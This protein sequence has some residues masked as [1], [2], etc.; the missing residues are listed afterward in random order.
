MQ[1]PSRNVLANLCTV[2]PYVTAQDADAG[3]DSPNNYPATSAVALPC[4][5]QCETEERIDEMGRVTLVNAWTV[6]FATADVTGL[7]MKVNDRIDLL[8][9]DGMSVARSVY[10]SAGL[11]MA[12]RQIATEVSC[13]EVR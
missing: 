12:S 7:G 8:T 4:S 9:P 10:V 3:N 11:D 5:H 2:Y 1:R 13:R 6:I